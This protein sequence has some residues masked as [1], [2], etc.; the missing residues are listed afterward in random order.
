MAQRLT[1]AA[2]GVYIIAATPFTDDGA[3]DLDSTDR[4]VDFC[5][6]A[7]CDGITIPLP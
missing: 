7:G 6:Q 2:R 3:L 5:L 4:M 1:E